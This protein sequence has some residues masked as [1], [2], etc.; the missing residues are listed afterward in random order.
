MH[1]LCTG[2][3]TPIAIWVVGAKQSQEEGCTQFGVPGWKPKIFLNLFPIFA[4]GCSC[5]TDR[6]LLFVSRAQTSPPHTAISAM[7]M[8]SKC[9]PSSFLANPRAVSLPGPRSRVARDSA[10]SIITNTHPGH[11]GF[12]P[13]EPFGPKASILFPTTWKTKHKPC[14]V[15]AKKETCCL[16]LRNENNSRSVR[17]YTR[18]ILR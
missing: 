8:K 13:S 7:H 3:Q 16:N 10:A 5:S 4:Q 11:R 14:L 6:H 2:T 18:C 9:L 15:N 1:V 17:L 12:F